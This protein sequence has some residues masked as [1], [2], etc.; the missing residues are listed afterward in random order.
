MKAAFIIFN[1]LLHF[2]TFCL[3]NTFV[4]KTTECNALFVNPDQLFG[5]ALARNLLRVLYVYPVIE[6]SIIHD[7]SILAG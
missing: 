3:N 7:K 2:S 4:K 5:K 6:V 1:N